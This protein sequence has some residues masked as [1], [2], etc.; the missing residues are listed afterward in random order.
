LKSPFLHSRSCHH[1]GT[2]QDDVEANSEARWDLKISF[3]KI[4]NN[5]RRLFFKNLNNFKMFRTRES[6]HLKLYLGNKTANINIFK[7]CHVKNVNSM[8]M[9]L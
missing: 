8:Q 1:K 9:Q 7:N 6:G 2:W 3:L 4:R 5:V